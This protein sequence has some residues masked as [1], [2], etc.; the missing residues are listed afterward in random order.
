[1]K[2]LRLAKANHRIDDE[3]KNA[4]IK[5]SK[6][7]ELASLIIWIAGIVLFNVLK[8]SDPLMEAILIIISLSAMVFYIALRIRRYQY[9][10]RN[11]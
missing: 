8:L 3:I 5:K 9:E 7:M 1:M 6:I 11:K 10:S 4:R 2:A